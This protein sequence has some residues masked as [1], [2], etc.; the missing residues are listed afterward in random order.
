MA[1]GSRVA[2]RAQVEGLLNTWSSPVIV[3]E[4]KSRRRAS[5]TTSDRAISAMLSDWRRQVGVGQMTH[6]LSLVHA[7]DARERRVGF[8]CGTACAGNAWTIRMWFPLFDERLLTTKPRWRRVGTHVSSRMGSWCSDSDS[9]QDEAHR[10]VERSRSLHAIL[11]CGIAPAL[12]FSM[13]RCS[14]LR[15]VRQTT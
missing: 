2:C 6:G 8:C 14:E 1:E 11:P 13:K 9:E 3:L 15:A 12:R 7:Q 5:C 4:L 10:A